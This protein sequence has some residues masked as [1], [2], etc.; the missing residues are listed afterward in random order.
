MMIT[1]MPRM[2][3]KKRRRTMEMMKMMITKPM[4]RMKKRTMRNSSIEMMVVTVEQMIITPMISG[5]PVMKIIMPMITHFC[6]LVRAKAHH[7]NSPN[8]RLRE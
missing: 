1:M 7:K 5:Q 8:K 4:M 6:Q 3:K 2:N